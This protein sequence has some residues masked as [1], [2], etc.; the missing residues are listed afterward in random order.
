MP[1]GDLHT[2]SFKG[3]FEERLPFTTRFAY[4]YSHE[5]ILNSEL[6]LSFVLSLLSFCAF[7]SLL[8]LV[9]LASANEPGR[10]GLL[11]SSSPKR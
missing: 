9:R 2:S 5:A 10:G 7:L 11:L 8:A 6:S 4:I 3:K 1:F